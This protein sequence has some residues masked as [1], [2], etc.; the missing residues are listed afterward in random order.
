M[1]PMTRVFPRLRLHSAV[2][3]NRGVTVEQAIGQATKEMTV[4]RDATFSMIGLAVEQLR[5]L[6][7]EAEG[8]ISTAEVLTL[9]EVVVDLAGL[10]SAPLCRAAQSLCA[11]CDKANA[12]EHVSRAAI[13]VHTE[14]I[15]LLYTM[16]GTES[17]TASAIVEGLRSV[18]V[19]AR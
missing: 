1:K 16:G 14:A 3:G 12:G 2:G 5:K 8:D 18:V 10:Y 15:H 17:P 7:G 19:K 9:A 13:Q 4:H 11:L 6:S